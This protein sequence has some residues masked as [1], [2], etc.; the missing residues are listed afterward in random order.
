M[1]LLSYLRG[2]GITLDID[3]RAEDR[4]LTPQTVP[5]VMLPYSRHRWHHHGALLDANPSTALRIADAY[6]CVRVLS[7]AVASL[8]PNVYRQTPTGRVRVGD[9]QRLAALLKRPSPGSTSADLFGTVMA[10]LNTHG[11]AFVGKYRGADG[12]IV[13][14]GCLYPSQVRVELRGNVI[15]YILSRTDGVFELGL[16]DVLHIKAMSSDGPGAN[17][18]LGLSPVAQCRLALSLSANLQESARQFFENGSMPSGVMSIEG[19]SEEGVK[20]FEEEWRNRQSLQAGKFHSIAVV[21]AETSFTPIAFSERDTQFLE[22]RQLSAVEVARCFRVPPRLIGAASGDS[23]TYSNVL[24]ENRHFVTHSLRPW[25]VRIE[26]AFSN[27]AE[28]CPG[29]TFLEFDLDALLRA[30]L[31]TRSEIYQ[32]ALGDDKHPAWMTVNEIR[33]AESLPPLDTTP[34]TGGI[35]TP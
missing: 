9:D 25:L 6:S 7:D 2:D 19:A 20:A 8:P 33:E 28:L 17:G 10:H 16:S 11:N 21:N 24:E 13:Q 3:E 4:T 29:G 26:R 15:T 34:P 12:E 35:T 1:G 30:D 22:Q 23:M 5:P 18:L 27:D 32:R 14:L 31:A